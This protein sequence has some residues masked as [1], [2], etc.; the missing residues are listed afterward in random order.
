MEQ[1][2][3]SIDWDGGSTYLGESELLHLIRGYLFKSDRHFLSCLYTFDCIINLRENIELLNQLNKDVD[4]VVGSNWSMDRQ[5]AAENDRVPHNALSKGKC[6]AKLVSDDCVVLAFF[7][8]LDTLQV[9]NKGADKE[10]SSFKAGDVEDA[11][12]SRLNLPKKAPGKEEGRDASAQQQFSV[13]VAEEDGTKSRAVRMSV[14]ADD[15]VLYQERRRNFREGYKS[16]RMGHYQGSRDDKQSY[17]RDFQKLRLPST[18]EDHEFCEEISRRASYGCDFHLLIESAN[19]VM[20]SGFFQVAF[21]EC[22]LTRLSTDL[23]DS[24]THMLDRVDLPHTILKQLFFSKRY[25]KTREDRPALPLDRSGLWKKSPATRSPSE[26][27][28]SSHHRQSSDNIL[29]SHRFRKKVKRAHEH[30]FSRGVYM[31]LREGGA[32]QHSDLLQALSSCIEVPMDVDITLLYRMMETAASNKIPPLSPAAAAVVS[33]SIGADILKDKL[34][35]SFETILSSVFVPIAGTKYYYFTGNENTV[36][37]DLSSSDYDLHVLM[38]DSDDNDGEAGQKRDDNQSHDDAG[39]GSDQDPRLQHSRSVEGGNTVTHRRSEKLDAE[40]GSYGDQKRVYRRRGSLGRELPPP[41]NTSPEENSSSEQHQANVEEDAE[42]NKEVAVATSSFSVPFFFRFEC[43]VLNGSRDIRSNSADT[44][45]PGITPH[46]DVLRRSSSTAAYEDMR[47][48][49]VAQ[50]QLTSPSS[51]QEEFNAFLASLKASQGSRRSSTSADV[52]HVAESFSDTPLGRIALRLV[53]LTLPNERAFDGGRVTS[54]MPFEMDNHSGQTKKTNTLPSMRTH[55]F[56]TLHLFQRQVLTRVRK[57]IKEWCSVEILSI[58][59]SANEITPAIGSLVQRLFDDLPDDAVTKSKYP[60]E[61]V[62]RSQ[63]TPVNP[64]DL[65]KREFE[66]GDLLNVH[67]CN[68]VY[69]VVENRNSADTSVD[70]LITGKSKAAVGAPDASFEIPYWAYFELGGD[71]ISLRLHHPDRF[72]ASSGGFNRLEVLTRLQLGVRAVCRRVNQFLLL[73]QLHETRTCNGLLL[74]PNGNSPSSPRSLKRRNGSLGTS[75]SMDGQDGQRKQ[76]NFFWPGQF[77]CDLRYSA[78]FKL[79]ERLAPNFAL[80]ILCTSA[81]EHFQVHNRRH[82]FVYR[83]RDGHVFYMKIS[84]YYDTSLGGQA[85]EERQE[86]SGLSRSSTGGSTV[87]VTTAAIPTGVPGIRLEVFGVSDP[88]EEVTHELCRLLERKL[89]E[90]T[91]VVLMKLLA[92]NTKFQLSQTDLAFLCPPSAPPASVVEYILPGEVFE[93]SRLL[94]YLSQTLKLSPYVRPVSSG[95]SFSA[96]NSREPAS[97]SFRRVR[98]G[99]LASAGSTVSL[100][101]EESSKE[102]SKAIISKRFD[103]ASGATVG[104]DDTT[105]HDST[106]TH[107]ACFGDYRKALANFQ[108]HDKDP[109]PFNAAIRSPVFFLTTNGTEST[110]CSRVDVSAGSTSSNPEFVAQTSYVLNLNPDLRLSPGFMSRVGKGLALM[111]V[112]LIRNIPAESG[113]ERKEEIGSEGIQKLKR[114]YDIPGLAALYPKADETA[115]QDTI[116]LVARCQVWI[117]GSIHTAEL[118]QVVEAFLDEALY[119]YHIEATIKK[120]GIAMQRQ[121]AGSSDTVSGEEVHTD[122]LDLSGSHSKLP[123]DVDTLVSLFK[124]ACLLPSSS[125]TNL[126][127]SLSIAPWDLENAVAQVRSFL[128]CLPHHLRPAVYAKSKLSG[129]YESIANRS[130]SVHIFSNSSEPYAEDFRLVVKHVGEPEAYDGQDSSDSDA[131]TTASMSSALH[132]IEPFMRTDSIHSEISDLDSV[133]GRMPLTWASTGAS[134]DSHAIPTAPSVSSTTSSSMVGVMAGLS[135]QPHLPKNANFSERDVLLYSN[136]SSHHHQ[137]SDASETSE[138][139]RSFYY[140]VDLSTSKGLQLY[141]YNMSSALVEALATH[142]ARVLTWSMLREKLLRSLLLEK[143]GIS[144]AVPIGSI[145]LQPRSLFL[146][147][148]RTERTGKSMSKSTAVLCKDS[149]VHF[150]EYRPPVLSILQ[151]NEWFP[152]VLD[153]SR[154]RSIDGFAMGTYLREAQTQ[155]AS[156]ALESQYQRPRGKSNTNMG[157]QMGPPS[158]PDLS[159]EVSGPSLSQRSM[160]SSGDTT[161][162]SGGQLGRTKSG[163]I[164]TGSN[165]PDSVSSSPNKRLNGPGPG[166]P[167]PGGNRSDIA[168]RIRGGAGAATALMAARARARGGGLPSRMSGGPGISGTRSASSGSTSTAADSVAPWDLPL[169]NTKG[170]RLHTSTDG[171]DSNAATPQDADDTGTHPGSNTG[172]VTATSTE[173]KPSTRRRGSGQTDLVTKSS[174]SSLS[175]LPLASPSVH[176][177]SSKETAAIDP[178][179]I[180]SSWKKR[181]EC[182]WGPRFLFPGNAERWSAK[183]TAE[184]RLHFMELEDEEEGVLPKKNHAPLPYFCAALERRWE[185][186]ETRSTS[187][188]VG[189]NLLGRLASMSADEEMEEPVAKDVVANMVASGHLLLHQRFRAAFVERWVAAE[190]VGASADEDGDNRSN[191]LRALQ[192]CMDL[193]NLLSYKREFVFDSDECSVA[194]LYTEHTVFSMGAGAGA[195]VRGIK[196]QVAAN[197]EPLRLEVASEFYKEFAV[198][199]RTLGFRQLRTINTSRSHV[200]A[201]PVDHTAASEGDTASGEGFS[202]YFY[203]PE[204]AAAEA[205]GWKMDSRNISGDAYPLSVVVLEVKCDHRGV[206]LTAV[207]VSIHDLEQQDL[208]F[209]NR[210]AAKAGKRTIPASGA[211]IQCVA[212]WLR[213]QLKTQALIYGFTICYFQQHL[214]QWV[215][216]SHDFLGNQ[217][218]A[219]HSVGKHLG[220]DDALVATPPTAWK[221][222]ST[223]Q[224]IVKGLQCFL[225]AFPDPPEEPQKSSTTLLAAASASKMIAD[226]RAATTQSNDPRVHQTTVTPPGS[227]GPRSSLRPWR[228]SRRAAAKQHQHH[229]QSAHPELA[230]APRDAVSKATAP[231]SSLWHD[232]VIC[233]ETVTLQPTSLQS[234]CVESILVQILLR[235]IACHGSRYELL[236]LLQFGTPDAVV[237]HSSSG[238]FFHRP[239]STIIPS[240]PSR[241]V[242]PSGGYSLVITTQPLTRKPLDKDSVQLL[243]LKSTPSALGVGNGVLPV[244]RALQEAQLFT[245]ELFR[246]AAQ[247]YERDLLWSRLLFDDTRGPGAEVAR[248]LALPTDLFRVEVGPQQL[249]ECLRLSI[250]TP[251]ETLDPRLDELLCVSGVCWQELALR[252]RDIYADQLREFQFQE[253]D[254]N[255][256]HLLLL[257]PDTFDLI[258]HLTFITP[259]DQTVA[260]AELVEDGDAS[261]SGDE[262]IS[263]SSRSASINGSHVSGIS[264]QFSEGGFTQEAQGDVRVEICRREEPPNK[265]FTFAQRRSISEFV[266][267]IVHWQW[268]SLIYD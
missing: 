125:V 103:E 124:S 184:R 231:L 135:H 141:G 201:F 143:S 130:D 51:R 41:V 133:S 241:K 236:D 146:T 197:L 53:T 238:R 42:V 159:R 54:A 89:D 60:L 175:G 88:G 9:R 1:E 199:L 35:K 219:S 21:Y 180:H 250:C 13:R 80:N 44:H 224:N 72:G 218:G 178:G 131:E 142:L 94:H 161:S 76:A 230:P 263:S 163:G 247:H 62:T 267:C 203:H 246:V 85:T 17:G 186:F 165:V 28:A 225:H 194:K 266:N 248:T 27:G 260:Q 121:N 40:A 93:C 226:K 155:P 177:R 183:I 245:R 153:A 253:E 63:E 4:G 43:R 108:E 233:M 84:I 157:A 127:V 120:L 50:A 167:Y 264:E 237:C 100:P 19:G 213:A 12:E 81:L 162:H 128:S 24:S 220:E 118:S 129:A 15:I 196:Q 92:R 206:R 254:E 106:R 2:D 262:S 37:E 249:E 14:S 139:K 173:L 147:I 198:H 99:S 169:H 255:S 32:V 158:I 182:A 234:N 119:D 259:K 102:S 192:S 134:S 10:A 148:G 149:A 66:K 215:D 137:K 105:D 104:A 101:G 6:F 22:S 222:A 166:M 68:G 46:F 45:T 239:P 48:D 188:T 29:A 170:P 205:G 122:I 5:M 69:F 87:S 154:L 207:L 160:H 55:N 59:K 91:Q 190:M 82:I 18:P 110:A 168:T 86:R 117:R 3:V 232:C 138:V 111:R 202:E 39:V 257:C 38:E 171:A 71:H 179:R 214:L 172:A 64:I 73:L 23:H 200:R 251:L 97:G 216:A 115:E 258:I 145:V 152:R 30:N 109:V 49:M 113:D 83:D 65:F 126:G 136:S 70:G 211:R 261:V 20:G 67:H 58:L 25:S 176:R 204:K 90:A 116:P 123:D 240:I 227:G 244:E 228:F 229:Q 144:A 11:F 209:Q 26:P 77:E 75:D 223:F 31:A 235:Y 52:T 185:A 7:P 79:H 156:E 195:D 193:V 107:P 95:G 8:S 112:D 47:K 217:S 221:K 16:W 36:Y 57:D 243:L 114:V 252:L 140:V 164:V 210:L 96:R 34:T 265:Q 187:H 181:L 212:A 98:R 174:S 74:P 56:S 268:R 33:A 78:F 151:S 191:R 61:F 256:S 132:H 242:E 189:I 208:R 150:I